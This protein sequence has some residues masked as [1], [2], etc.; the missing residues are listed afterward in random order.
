MRQTEGIDRIRAARESLQGITPLLRDCGKRCGAA[1][2]SP[3]EEGRGGMLLFPGEEALYEPAP[4]WATLTETDW[5]VNGKP[6]YLL[7]CN[8]ACP[9]AERPLA[10]RLFPLT[11]VVERGAVS[12]CLDVRAWPVCPL[13]EHGVSG[14]SPAFVHAAKEAVARLCGDADLRAYIEALTVRLAAY[15]IL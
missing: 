7:T 10:C 9:R 5:L 12:V 14:L 3:D 6:L 2:C 1:C 8:G 15:S 11:P 4:D 13:M